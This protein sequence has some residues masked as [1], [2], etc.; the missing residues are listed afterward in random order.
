MAVLAGRAPFTAHNLEA[1][2]LAQSSFDYL[3][4]LGLLFL[5]SWAV[6]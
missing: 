2:C 1:Q 3:A 6:K 4:G 5:L